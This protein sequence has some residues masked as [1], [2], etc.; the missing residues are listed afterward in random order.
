M[1]TEAIAN[2]I[3]IDEETILKEMKIDAYLEA[4]M[5]ELAIN[6]GESELKVMKESGTEED[7]A[8]LTE[9][10]ANGAIEKIQKTVKAAIETFKEF[11]SRI[12]D[13]V[14]KLITTKETKETMKKVEKKIKLNPFL[15]KKKVQVVDT[16]KPLKVIS[17]YE[18]A[19]DTH[20]AK[21]ASG[22]VKPGDSK[23]I[24]GLKS[25]FQTEYKAAIMGV[26]A[27][28]TITVAALVA[29]VNR[30]MESLNS[31]VNKI[32]KDTSA[33]LNKM[34]ECRAFSEE[35]IAEQQAAMAKIV[36]FRAILGREKS[37]ELVDGLSNKISVL[38]KSVAGAVKGKEVDAV[39]PKDKGFKFG[40][41]KKGKAMKES[42][43]DILGI[44]DDDIFGESSEDLFDE[45]DLFEESESEEIFG[46]ADDEDLMEESADDMLDIDHLFEESEE[47]TEDDDLVEESTIDDELDEIFGESS[48]DI[49][50]GE[51]LF[52]ESDDDVSDD[53][54]FEESSEDELDD[55]FG[56]SSDDMSD[57]DH[58]F[59]ESEEDE[60]DDDLF[61]ESAGRDY[62]AEDLLDAIDDII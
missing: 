59:E 21:V 38:R 12:K 40:G 26:A 3:A 29:M 50:A 10:A 11:I 33:S 1:F 57:I 6:I 20:A 58:L 25:K 51:D 53:E 52:D 23:K 48:D 42:E 55:I 4:T 9:A 8:Y 47:D 24:D 28:T 44:D 18:S 43:D 16:K 15:A 49:F 13:R 19:L 32:D 62:S 36:S 56:E 35:T 37:N 14:V 39:I 7:L 22:K 31:G 34:A 41:K 54:S 61:G 60:E 46:F 5:R 45:G 30:D 17:K 2:Q 27:M